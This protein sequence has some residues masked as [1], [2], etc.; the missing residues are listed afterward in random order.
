[1][2]SVIL[3]APA[4]EIKHAAG[5]RGFQVECLQ[6]AIGTRHAVPLQVNYSLPFD[7]SLAAKPVPTS[8]LASAK[9]ERSDAR[10]PIER[11]ADGQVLVCIP[12]RAIVARI[13]TES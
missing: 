2:K 12:H 3:K 8:S 5:S 1:M 13:H 6:K 4:E 10:M 7:P 11:S 9:L